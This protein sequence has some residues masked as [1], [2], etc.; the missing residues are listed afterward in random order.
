MILGVLGIVLGVPGFFWGLYRSSREE[1]WK[2]IPWAIF[3][4]TSLGICMASILYVAIPGFFASSG[5]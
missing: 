2:T 4:V 1:G 5:L 3:S